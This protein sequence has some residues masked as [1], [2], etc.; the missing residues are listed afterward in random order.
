VLLIT[1]GCGVFLGQPA[2][3]H[4]WDL[5]E[6][7]S[8]ADVRWQS[9]AETWWLDHVDVTIRLPRGYTW[10]GINVMLSACRDP[11]QVWQVAL[12][13]SPARTLTQ[14][15]RQAK[16]LAQEWRMDTADLER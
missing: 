11:D 1:P 12:Y 8:K 16:Q 2:Q 9:H 5:R 10:A 15:Y 4:L 13:L 7:H 6:S 3:P 14:V